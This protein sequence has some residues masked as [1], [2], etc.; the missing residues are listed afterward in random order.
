MFAQVNV[1][2]ECVVLAVIDPE[3]PGT[4]MG[5]LSLSFKYTPLTSVE[6]LYNLQLG[7]QYFINIF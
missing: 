4:G 6:Y 1:M 3:N 2:C 7:L 5:S